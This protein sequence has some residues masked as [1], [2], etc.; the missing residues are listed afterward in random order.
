MFFHDT[1]MYLLREM[2]ELKEVLQIEGIPALK[3]KW[4]CNEQQI[5]LTFYGSAS[6]GFNSLEQFHEF[7]SADQLTAENSD[8]PIDCVICM[9]S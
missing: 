5:D 3:L 1:L 6:S 4:I 8:Q 7:L 9:D 2:D